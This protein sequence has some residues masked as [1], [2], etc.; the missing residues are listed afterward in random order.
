MSR[1]LSADSQLNISFGVNTR[2]G[3]PALIG[4]DASP[5]WNANEVCE[6]NFILSVVDCVG[7][8]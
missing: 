8:C 1:R 4:E 7:F 3:D 5:Y 2:H 6:D